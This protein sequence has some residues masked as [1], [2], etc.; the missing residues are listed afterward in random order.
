MVMCGWSCICTQKSKLHNWIT[1]SDGPGTGSMLQA[2]LMVWLM[3][4]CGLQ[5]LQQMVG[6]PIELYYNA[7]Q[8]FMYTDPP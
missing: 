2:Y 1:H 7:G 3:M 4:A 5:D 8:T 6:H